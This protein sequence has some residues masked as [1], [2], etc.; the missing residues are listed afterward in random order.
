MTRK[1]HLGP[2]LRR[3]APPSATLHPRRSAPLGATGTAAHAVAQTGLDRFVPPDPY[4]TFDV[5]LRDGTAFE[6]AVELASP[7]ADL[8]GLVGYA[9]C[10]GLAGFALKLDVDVAGRDG[11]T[12]ALSVAVSA[13]GK[14]L[15][16]D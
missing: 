12:R 2:P 3:F 7:D 8:G 11:A 16:L 13:A 5:R 6:V 14:A 10:G 9:V 15:G 1:L 4:V